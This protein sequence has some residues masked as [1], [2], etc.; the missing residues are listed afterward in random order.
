MHEQE[1]ASNAMNYEAPRRDTTS[2]IG[3]I[4]D[5]APTRP[6]G[7]RI[8][9]ITQLNHGYIVGVGCQSFAV[10]SSSTLIAKLAEYLNNPNATEQKW[11]EGKLF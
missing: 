8:I 1:V 4:G 6:N 3:Y 7:I 11:N 10:E 5:P 2:G 9:T